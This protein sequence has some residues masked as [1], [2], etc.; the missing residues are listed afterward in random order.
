MPVPDPAGTASGGEHGWAAAVLCSAPQSGWFALTWLLERAGCSF[1]SRLLEFFP[2]GLQ[3]SNFLEPGPAALVGGI[4]NAS[5]GSSISHVLCHHIVTVG[6][7]LLAPLAC[8][9]FHYF[10]C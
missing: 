9:A 4:A 1:G 3:E 2:G 6:F 10:W 8:D 7:C 5:G